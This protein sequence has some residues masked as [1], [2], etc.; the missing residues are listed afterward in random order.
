MLRHV[1]PLALALFASGCVASNGGEGMIILGNTALA[2][3]T[4]SCTFTGATGQP[5]LSGGQISILSPSPYLFTPLLESDIS[6]GSG[7]D[8]LT[9][10]ITL[11]G[12]NVTLTVAS[13]SLLAVNG[14]STSPSL[15]LSGTDAAFQAPFAGTLPPNPGTANVSFP[16][17]PLS[18]IA[19]LVQQAAPAVGDRLHVEL[20]AQITVFG[21]LGGSRINALPF[22]YPVTVCNDCVVRSDGACPLTITTPSLGNPCN[23]FQD[24]VVDCCTGSGGLMC[25]G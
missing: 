14:T 24:G 6:G 8:P 21:I 12:A 18:A 5:Y 7:V 2:A 3:G 25:P 15:S 9:R 19:T 20:Q 17:V 22:N 23:V 10:T 1:A 16:I 13:A 11:Q 4:T